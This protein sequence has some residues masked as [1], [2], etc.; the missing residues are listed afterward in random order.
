VLVKD[1][2]SECL[3]TRTIQFPDAFSSIYRMAI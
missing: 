1:R 3:N 2:Y